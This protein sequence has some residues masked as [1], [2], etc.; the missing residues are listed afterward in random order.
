MIIVRSHH[1]LTFF[2]FNGLVRSSALRPVGSLKSEACYKPRL[3]LS[4]PKRNLVCHRL[5]YYANTNCAYQHTEVRF[6]RN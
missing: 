6:S 5:P 1:L 3:F 2:S 4:R